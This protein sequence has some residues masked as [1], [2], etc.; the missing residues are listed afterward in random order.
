M[1]NAH[2]SDIW[3]SDVEKSVELYNRW[4]MEFAPA[5]YEKT[6]I[7][8]ASDVQKALEVLDNLMHIT[9]EALIE[10]PTIIPVLR[11]C[12]SPPLARDRLTGLAGLTPSL[13]VTLEN[14]NALPPRMKHTEIMRNFQAICFVI[15]NLLDKNIFT[16]LDK[17]KQPS[18]QEIINA[19]RIVADRLCAAVANPIIKNAQEKRQLDLIEQYLNRLGYKKLSDSVPFEKMPR[20]TYCFRMNIP[21]ILSENEGTTVNLPIDVVIRRR[22]AA[23]DEFP[24][25]IECKSAGD[26]TNTNKRR[27]EEAIKMIQ[28]RKTYGN[29][30]KL[31]LFLCGYFDI[32]YL[33]YEAA[34]GLDWIWEH[35]I[36]DMEQ[37]KL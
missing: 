10:N 22:Y 14:T 7:K 3:K 26:F 30:A 20:G 28:L 12:T 33:R 17:R 27:K 29:K 19:S 25:L 32:G 15:S 21:V 16:W 4:F 37:L 31:Y 18:S 13:L 2:R 34:E 1:I 5:V 24:I 9:P 11:M 6:R 23:K 36:E 35:R 8:V